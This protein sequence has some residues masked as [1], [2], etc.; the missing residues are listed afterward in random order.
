M[1]LATEYILLLFR[2]KYTEKSQESVTKRIEI[3]EFDALTVSYMVNFMYFGDYSCDSTEKDKEPSSEASSMT[4]LQHVK[5]VAIA[6][7][8]QI[9]ELAVIA[10]DKI[11][12]IF[13]SPTWLVTSYPEAVKTAYASTQNKELRQTLMLAGG[14]RIQ[15]LVELQDFTFFDGLDEIPATLIGR[16]IAE[17]QP[18]TLLRRNVQNVNFDCLH[19]KRLFKLGNESSGEFLGKQA[20][21]MKCRTCDKPYSG[22]PV[23]R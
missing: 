23:R 5:I 6:E 10:I 19:C 11:K 14:K 20:S 3:K 12:Q 15:E 8:Y 9:S 16:V 17:Q 18:L 7:Y 4:L 22:R 2:A 21:L 13:K 1:E